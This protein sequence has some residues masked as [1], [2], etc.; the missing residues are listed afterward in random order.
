MRI[1]IVE[2]DAMVARSLE[3][4]LQIEGHEVTGKAVDLASAVQWGSSTR[5][6]LALIDIQLANGSNGYDVAAELG[7]LS[8]PCIFASANVPCPR[9]PELALGCLHK[10]Y[11][12]DCLLAATAFARRAAGSIEEMP[13]SLG[14]F[15][16]Y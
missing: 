11:R 5:P 3:F 14:G 8:I 13:Q 1:L 2:D 10:P 12:I 6:D 7:R 4:L 16:P 9:R 15:E